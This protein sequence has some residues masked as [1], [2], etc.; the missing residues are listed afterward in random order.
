VTTA[1]TDCD[2][3]RKVVVEIYSDVCMMVMADLVVVTL[4]PGV[5]TLDL[6]VVKMDLVVRRP[7]VIAVWPVMWNVLATDCN[8]EKLHQR[9]NLT[10]ST[11]TL[12]DTTHSTSC[13]I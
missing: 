11:S 1:V 5:V 13:T 3:A 6:G 2:A 12:L 8:T 7:N 10:N 9:L 4:D